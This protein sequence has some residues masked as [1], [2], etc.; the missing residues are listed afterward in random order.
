MSDPDT[1]I[2]FDEGYYADEATTYTT[3]TYFKF[4]I[5]PVDL[6]LNSDFTWFYDDG[7]AVTINKVWPVL[8]R[9]GVVVFNGH[10]WKTDG[11]IQYEHYDSFFSQ[12]SSIDIRS[13]H[14][15]QSPGFQILYSPK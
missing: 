2:S 3:N 13:S 11:A 15:L 14:D 4:G 1:D 9:S 10:F 7:D 12:F 5:A 6:E 8:L